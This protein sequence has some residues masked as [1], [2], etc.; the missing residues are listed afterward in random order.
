M[1]SC[2]RKGWKTF[3]GAALLLLMASGCAFNPSAPADVGQ[4]QASANLTGMVTCRVRTVLPPDAYMQ[5]ELVDISRQNA[6]AKTISVQEIAL[7]GR[8]VP[9]PF[10]I[11]YGP[12]TIDPSHA[13]A[14]QV[15]ILQG[16]R[17]LFVNTSID[18][19]LTNGVRS[20]IEVVVEPVPGS[21]V[22]H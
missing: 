5:V 10:S 20:N 19:V 17:L 9:I 1:A 11:A 18:R 2:T 21:G 7:E 12:G 22:G 13:Y 4:G 15:R 3:A 8:Q 14:V 6:P 16:N